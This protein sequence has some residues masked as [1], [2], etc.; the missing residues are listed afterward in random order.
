MRQDLDLILF[1]MYAFIF[2]GYYI[3]TVSGEN[4]LIN[5]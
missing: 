5:V 2:L 4:Y 3:K 1:L